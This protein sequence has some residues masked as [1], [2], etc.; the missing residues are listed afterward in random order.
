MV[1]GTHPSNRHSSYLHPGLQRRLHY[2]PTKCPSASLPMVRILLPMDSQEW[3]YR[4]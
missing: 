3:P 2:R 1:G 4:H